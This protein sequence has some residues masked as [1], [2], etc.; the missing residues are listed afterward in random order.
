MSAEF[1][2]TKQNLVASN[3]KYLC[4]KRGLSLRELAAQIGMDPSTIYRLT[5][6]DNPRT[7]QLR[8]LRSLADFFKVDPYD[9][10]N[11]NFSSRDFD[12]RIGNPTMLNFMASF[13]RQISAPT[14]KDALIPLIKITDPTT[15]NAEVLSLWSDRLLEEYEDPKAAERFGFY[16]E[17]WIRTP[18]NVT[19]K[20]LVAMEVKTNAMAPVLQKGDIVYVAGFENRVFRST[21]LNIRENDIVVANVFIDICESE[22]PAI[23]IRRAVKNEAGTINLAAENPVWPCEFYI[24]RSYLGKVV[25][26]SRKL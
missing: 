6:D 13:D 20:D 14:A 16:I 5:D 1:K 3:I 2:A 25:G 23:V 12:K 22:L 10:S 19:G 11:L 17:K 15:F 24:A 18:C 9:L 7:P 21:D 26:V 4:Q 8:T